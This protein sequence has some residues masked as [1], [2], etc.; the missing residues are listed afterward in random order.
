MKS[1]IEKVKTVV[2]GIMYELAK[3]LDYITNGFIRAWHVTLISLVGHIFVMLAITEGLFVDA[4]ILLI[5]FGLMDALDGAVAKYQGNASTTGM[6]LDSTTDRLKE[7]LIYAGFAYY[8]ATLNDELGALYAV[9]ALG[10]SMSVSYVKSKGEVALLSEAKKTK[11]KDINRELESGL[12]G[13]EVRMFILVI[14]LFANEPFIG[15]LVVTA[16]AILTFMTRF[17]DVV[18]RLNDKN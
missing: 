18:S 9:I 6:L 5:G 4:A 2:R 14:A 17:H 16:G 1:V 8:F 10:I 11:K 12:F 13:Y 7:M 15:I 3:L